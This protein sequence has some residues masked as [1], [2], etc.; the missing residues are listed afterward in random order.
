VVIKE[1]SLI[2]VNKNILEILDEKNQMKHT[3]L[4]NMC[5]NRMGKKISK[6]TFNKSITYLLFMGHIKKES[7][8]GRGDPKVYSI[9]G[10][11]YI[12]DKYLIANRERLVKLIESDQ[13]QYAAIHFQYLDIALCILNR[14]LI[15][16][17]M[18]YS[19]ARTKP[20]AKEIFELYIEAKMIPFAREILNLVKSPL[21]IED[22]TYIKLLNVFDPLNH[23][24]WL[25]GF[26]HDPGRPPELWTEEERKKREEIMQEQWHKIEEDIEKSS[27]KLDQ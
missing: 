27:W 24:L 12:N 22:S 4:L 1:S 17:L 7:P 19:Q 6:H 15:H 16:A 23:S 18:S 9:D 11:Q 20:E 26:K 10:G 13:E 14:S 21:P 3:D 2:E 25:Q 5:R 8:G